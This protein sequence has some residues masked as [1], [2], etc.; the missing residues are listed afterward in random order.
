MKE[1]TFKA[2]VFQDFFSNS[3]YA[4]EPNIGNIDFIVTEKKTQKDNIWPRHYL[5]AE[6]KK[7]TAEVYPMLTQ[8]VLTAKKIYEKGEHL[9]PP[10]IGCFD[11]GKI[12]F[13][14]FHDILPIF[15]DND[16]NW[17]ITPSNHTTDDFLK[18]QKKVEKLSKKNIVFFQFDK[19]TKEIKDFINNNLV[20][21]KKQSKFQINKNNFV[22]I[23]TKWLEKVKKSIGIDW[24]AVKKA[25]I[26]D[27][28]FFLADLLSRENTTFKDKLFV[29]LQNN[30]YRFDKKLDDAG[31]S[32]YKEVGFNDSQKAHKEFWNKYER[33][34]LEEY[35]DYIIK[36]RDLLVPQDIRERKGSFFTPRQWVELSQKYIADVLGEDWQDEYYVWDCAAGTGNLLAGLTNKYNVW[37][38]TLDKADV[39][40]MKDRIKHGANLLEGNVFQF[41]F[42]N[43]SFDKL[44]KGLLNI[45]NDEK[46]RKKLIIYINPP[47]AEGDAKIGK[48]R[49]GIQISNIQSCYKQQLGKASG[50]LFAQFF[51]RIYCEIPDC[52][53]ANFSK[54]KILQAPNFA[55]F[56]EY[57]K[58]KLKKLFLVPADSFDNVKGQF[59]IGF[60]IWDL[61]I[62]ERFK[63]IKTH[64]YDHEGAFFG[65]KEIISYDKVK[66]ISEWL[67]HQSKEI[68][69]NYIGHL[70]SV[71][72]DFQHQRDVYI[73][74]VN[75]PKIKGGRHT[76]IAVENLIVVSIY[77][78]V[79]HCIN[80]DWL[81]DRDQF[82]YPNDRWENDTEFQSDCFT[83]TIF[84]INIQSKYGVNHWIPFTE[85]EVNAHSAFDSHFM[86]SF[87]G[88]KIIPNSYSDLF[89]DNDKK[90]K[91]LK[92]S[93]EAKSVFKAGK[94]LWQYYHSQPSANV[95]A[96]LYDIREYFQGRDAAAD[97]RNGKMNSKSGDD[98]YNVLIGSLRSALKTLAEKIQP[99]V[100]EYGFLLG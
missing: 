57:F 20:A 45:I 87:I 26:I 65:K 10:F 25:D 5:W 40:V 27:G 99:K 3:K 92:F 76:I 88:G 16:V 33:P 55:L 62:K 74:D 1:E 35:W 7:G 15:N 63:K 43:D 70:A 82:L 46:R 81:N 24:A 18:T 47:Y 59:P 50:E 13:V 61:S 28:D 8:L 32:L 98:V 77:F 67:E 94:K 56:R 29:I 80:A 71:G 41:D 38:S 72:N 49:K 36:R 51:I 19:D 100:Y 2:R 9:P 93:A 75:R 42:L 48:G 73:D 23:Y 34:P 12:A 79:R 31:F 60:F 17:N 96:S 21:G 58:P 44:P 89:F 11:T 22:I 37:V 39:N 30:Q 53:L 90:L 84:N 54:L 6:S 95:N 14:P 68:S 86:T 97:G 91:P 69:E 4:Y 78:A 66:Y 52:I 83:F 85:E 64:L